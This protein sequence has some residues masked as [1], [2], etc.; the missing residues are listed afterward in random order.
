MTAIS[1]QTTVNDLTQP[2]FMQSHRRRPLRSTRVQGRDS[3]SARRCGIF[4]FLPPNPMSP[5][6]APKKAPANGSAPIES[7]E[8]SASTKPIQSFRLKG[9]S[10]SVF[11]NRS[12]HD[13]PYF[14]IQLTRT[15]R[16]VDGFKTTNVFSRDDLPI[17]SLLADRAW[18]FVLDHEATHRKEVDS[19]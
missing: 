9:V 3:L 10:A 4:E 12:E 15:Y 7:P 11:E 16:A 2:I 18:Q 17:I 14:K 19:E 5:H 13:V 1:S 8:P 6:D